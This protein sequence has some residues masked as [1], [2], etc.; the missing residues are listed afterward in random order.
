MRKVKKGEK[1]EEVITKLINGGKQK[2]RHSSL[3]IAKHII[4]IES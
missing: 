1:G 3:M 2:F 4:H